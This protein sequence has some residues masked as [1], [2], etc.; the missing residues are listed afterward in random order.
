MG[1]SNQGKAAMSESPL[2]ERLHRR[3]V[4]SVDPDSTDRP[5]GIQR[6]QLMICETRTMRKEGETASR[7]GMLA[8]RQRRLSSGS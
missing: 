6:Q 7:G 5:S 1:E 3:R 4:P 8:A 2:Q